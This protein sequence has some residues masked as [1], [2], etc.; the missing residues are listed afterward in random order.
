MDQNEWVADNKTAPTDVAVDDF[1]TG[2]HDDRRRDEAGAL[3]ALFEQTT[4]T[5][6]VMWGPSI[7][8]FGTDH[9]RYASGREGNTARVGFSPRKTALT[10]YALK[11]HPASA[12]LLPS[13]GPYTEGK[14]CVYVK[15]L[16]QIDQDVLTQLVR[17]A[18]TR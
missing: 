6:A 4:G 5:T 15:R 18:W 17:L 8:G 7:I 12:E 10:F 1:L 16:D 9:Y 14:G 13:L 3:V 11:D 2:I